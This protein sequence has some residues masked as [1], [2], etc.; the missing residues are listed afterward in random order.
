MGLLF[1]WKAIYKDGTTLLQ[2]SAGN[3]NKFGNVNLANLKKF[4]IVKN[5]GNEIYGV[6]LTNGHFN[7]NGVDKKIVG[8]S[9]NNGYELINFRRIIVKV[10]NG[11]RHDEV[12]FHIGLKKENITKKI[13]VNIDGSVDVPQGLTL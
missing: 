3:E 8:F 7:I 5:S 11:V 9:D 4:E 10:I 1:D 13:I 12:N 2:N 6:D